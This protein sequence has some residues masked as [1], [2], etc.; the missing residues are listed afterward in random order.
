MPGRL[1]R[2]GLSPAGRSGFWPFD[3]G[4]EE[5][6]GFFGG[7]WNTASRFSRSAIRAKAASNRPTS[8]SSERMRSSFSAWLSVPR[9]IPC[10]TQSLNR[11]ARDRVNH[12]FVAR[13]KP[14]HGAAA[15]R[16]PPQVS[17]YP[18]CAA[19]DALFARDRLQAFGQ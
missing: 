16:R 2:G 7:R 11:V 5:L 12:H 9:S 15:R 6:S 3:G 1:L 13:R 8:G 18:L 17:N 19:V 14:L 10:V 4:S